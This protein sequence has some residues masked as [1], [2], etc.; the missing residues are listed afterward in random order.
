MRLV[1]VGVSHY[2]PCVFLGFTFHVVSSFIVFVVL[3][4]VW[5]AGDVH[6]L[7]VCA[8]FF[9]FKRA[10]QRRLIHLFFRGCVND[11]TGSMNL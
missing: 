3:G 4:F 1:S 9:F 7:L 5:S 2:A 6:P 11:S 8:C 10:H